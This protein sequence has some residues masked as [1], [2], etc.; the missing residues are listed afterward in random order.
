MYSS[1]IANLTNL[2]GLDGLLS[3]ERRI[4]GDELRVE[5]DTGMKGEVKDESMG[6]AWEVREIKLGLGL[7]EAI[8]MMG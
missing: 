5:R 8:E 3:V 1:I 6:R 4:L 7:G 2:I